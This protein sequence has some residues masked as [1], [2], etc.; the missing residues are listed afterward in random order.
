VLLGLRLEVGEIEVA[1]VVNLHGNDLQSGEV[2]RRRVGAMRTKGDQT[3]IP[4]S[5]ATRLVEGANDAETSVLPGSPRIRLERRRVEAGNLA[6][7]VLQLLDDGTVTLDLVLG[8]ER[9]D[10]AEF[11]PGKRNHAACAVELHGAATKGNHRVSE[12]EV[13]RGEVV[14]ISKHLSLG[15]ML[16]E[17]RVGQEL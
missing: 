17:H 15:M 10:A 5:F 14:D 16:V 11:R 6:E 4:V 1:V 9:V 3:D 8:S 2:G 12:A 13:L 7:I